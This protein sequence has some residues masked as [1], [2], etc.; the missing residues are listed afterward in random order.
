MP[1]QSYVNCHKNK[2]DGI[3]NDMKQIWWNDCTVRI[4]RN[5]GDIENMQS[6]VSQ[7]MYSKYTVNTG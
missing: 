3:N 6:M 1:Q 7:G 4:A 2:Y 5:H